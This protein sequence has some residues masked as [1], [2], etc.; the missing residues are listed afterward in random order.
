MIR[1]GA[2]HRTD[3][4]A[5]HAITGGH[6]GT[7]HYACMTTLTRSPVNAEHIES[8]SRCVSNT[9]STPANA[10]FTRRFGQH[11]IHSIEGYT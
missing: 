2:T 3:S 8:A 10:D 11:C 4:I 7:L 6:A 9:F 5:N 1:T